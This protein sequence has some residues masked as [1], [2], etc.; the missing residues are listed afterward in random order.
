M[1]AVRNFMQSMT[2]EEFGWYLEQFPDVLRKTLKPTPSDSAFVMD[3]QIL[4]TM[5][6]VL[7]FSPQLF[8]KRL[9]VGLNRKDVISVLDNF[10]EYLEVYLYVKTEKG[11]IFHEV[12][13]Q[14]EELLK[15]RGVSPRLA[16]KTA[17][18]VVV[19]LVNEVYSHSILN[20]RNGKH[21]CNGLPL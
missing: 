18:V 1:F 10:S 8:V 11:N 20:F 17:E 6:I 4:S 21:R 7:S 9:K 19:E 12:C 14:Y 3:G 2:K 15:E 16:R 5:Y 13:C